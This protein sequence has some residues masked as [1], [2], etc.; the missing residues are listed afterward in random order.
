LN[1]IQHK[2]VEN[3]WAFYPLSEFLDLSEALKI[4][5]ENNLNL[6]MKYN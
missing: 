1:F 4:N 3:E 2:Y 5:D 6:G